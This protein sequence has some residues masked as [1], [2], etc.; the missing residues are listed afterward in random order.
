MIHLKGL[1]TTKRLGTSALN[2][3]K[4]MYV[5]IVENMLCQEDKC[6]VK[7]CRL[8]DICCKSRRLFDFY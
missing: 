3:T 6:I 5:T 7:T 4:P 2:R 8:N 1:V